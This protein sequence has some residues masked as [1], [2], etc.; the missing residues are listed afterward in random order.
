MPVDGFEEVPGMAPPEAAARGVRHHRFS[1]DTTPLR[2]TKQIPVAPQR[3]FNW[4]DELISARNLIAKVFP[5]ILYVVPGILPEGLT[6]LVGRPKLG[7]SW[8]A[9]DLCIGV[10]SEAGSI[11][12]SIQ[13]GVRGDV[14]YLALEDNQ[15]RLQR[16]LK[17]L[18]GASEAPPRLDIQTQWRR[19]NEG[20]IDDVKA[21]F[22]EHPDAKLIVI[23]TLQ[24]VRPITREN[25]YAQDYMA[26]AALQQLA[27]ELGISILV[28]HHDRKAE[29]EDAFDTVSGTLGLTG[30]AD[31]ILLLKRDH[32]AGMCVLHGRGRDIEEFEKAMTFDKDSCLWRMTGDADEQRMSKERR[33]IIEAI[34]ALTENGPPGP[35]DI[36][37]AAKMKEA[38]VRVLLGKMVELGT[39]EKVQGETGKYQLPKRPDL[40]SDWGNRFDEPGYLPDYLPTL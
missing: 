26:V 37:A 5:D 29:A 14:L 13:P 1:G 6:L 28:L 20:G 21:W 11:M 23:D 8:L 27:G 19:T 17:K 12:T 10:A 9:F 40:G 22:A 30:A 39:V 31:A 4:R 18:L 24:A 35:K 38:N 33:K 25:G 3:A 34:D 32:T 15:R 2:R 16:R 7:K 36:A